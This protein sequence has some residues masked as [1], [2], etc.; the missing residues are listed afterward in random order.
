MAPRHA[1][2]VAPQK[3]HLRILVMTSRQL[4]IFPAMQIEAGLQGGPAMSHEHA[5]EL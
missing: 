2:M 1:S 4:T 3:V 5:G